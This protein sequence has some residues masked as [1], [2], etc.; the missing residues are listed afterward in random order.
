M[1]RDL[2]RPVVVLSVVAFWVAVGFGVVVPAL[3]LFA[4]EFGA[5]K[6][7]VGAVLSAFAGVRFLSALGVGRWVDVVGERLVLAGGIAVVAVSSVLAGLAHSYLQLLVLRGIGGFGSA[8]FTVGGLALLLRAAG[9]EHRARAAG[10]FQGGFLLGGIA[11]P[12]LGGPLIAWSI[13]APFF[14]YAGT[15]VIAG[16]VA[17]V[18]LRDAAFAMPKRRP[19]EGSGDLRRPEQQVSDSRMRLAEA[20]RRRPYQA[21]LVSNAAISWA[22]L[23]VRN[24]LVPLFVV[25]ALHAGPLWVGLGLTVMAAVNGVVLLPGGRL[26]DRRGRIGVLVLGCL[27]AAIAMALLA[28]W[29]GL[30]GYLLAMVVFGIGSGL[31]DVAPA[32]IVGDIAGGRGGTVVA[33]YQMAGDLGSVTGPL[34]AGWI[35]DA[36]GDRSA[37]WATSAVLAAAALVGATA[38]ETRRTPSGELAEI[39]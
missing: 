10:M 34:V 5:S 14:C 4:H 15:L 21:A 11:G 23:G 36:A 25:G 2:P 13:R 27:I 19:A 17:L 22:A 26:A 35:A 8:M 16:V 20:L 38:R 37:F 12:V 1:L 6:A 32:A 33:G 24:S 29:H 18:G 3:P 9:P 39:G 31:L 30:V 28:T 7:E